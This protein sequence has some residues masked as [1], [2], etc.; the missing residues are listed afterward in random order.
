M[1]RPDRQKKIWLA[2]TTL[3]DGEQA[4]GVVFTTRERLDI[5]LR[6]ARAGI[7]EIEA[8]IP[9]MGEDIC[10][11]I[12]KL[13]DLN[14]PCILTSWCRALQKDV[15]QAAGCQ[16]SGVH[17]SF[18]VSSIL[19]NVFGKDEAWVLNTLETLVIFA[20]QYFDRVSVGAQD[21]TRTRPEFL[22]L[23]CDLAHELGVDRI[24]LA[25]TVGTASPMTV[26][27]LVQGI[28]HQ[29]PGISLEF[30]GHNDLGMA[31]ANAVTA[32]EAGADALSVT[33]NGLGERAGNVPLEEVAAALFE[34]GGFQ[35]T[36]HMPL[37]ADLCKRVAR[38]SGRKIHSS[39][40]IIGKDNFRHESGIHCAGLLKDLST[41]QL[42]RP[43]EVGEKSHEY[44][45][46]YHSGS[47]SICRVLEDQGVRID[48]DEA[49]KLI[50]RIRRKAV[51][52]KRTL[53]PAELKM[54]YL[55]ET[56]TAGNSSLY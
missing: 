43:E 18:P 21:A 39:K 19:L 45:I 34:V 15:E 29:K 48:R 35:G 10:R 32:V 54:I 11:D 31:T 4:P 26:M 25:D 6:L 55:S 46:G 30:H 50:P 40:P 22:F 2:D 17:I 41:Y 9:A 13:V 36:I 12:R 38:A 28:L 52:A 53:T 51:A 56:R 44:V 49:G 3:R 33:V 1:S 42:F 47:A 7:N 20:R 8:G 5:A 23:F 24:R 27:K 14:L 16:T 37:M